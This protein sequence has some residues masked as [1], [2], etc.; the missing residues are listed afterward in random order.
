MRI[1]SWVLLRLEECIKVPEAAR[2]QNLVTQNL[3]FANK[4]C[5]GH[6]TAV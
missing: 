4:S 2:H 6:K 1:T 3:L 5:M